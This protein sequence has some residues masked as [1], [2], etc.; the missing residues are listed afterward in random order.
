VKVVP[1]KSAIADLESIADWIATDTP[2]RA[3]DEPGAR[4]A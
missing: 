2:E 4:E 3:P 1:A